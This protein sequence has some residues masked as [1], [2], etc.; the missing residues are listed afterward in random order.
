[1][2]KVISGM[3]SQMGVGGAISLTA[4]S[5]WLCPWT[6]VVEQDVIIEGHSR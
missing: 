2:V 3:A 1:M 5:D 4:L 6:M